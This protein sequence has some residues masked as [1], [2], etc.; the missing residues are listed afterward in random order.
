M[1]PKVAFAREVYAILFRSCERPAR[2]KCCVCSLV[3][4][5]ASF[6]AQLF[7]PVAASRRLSQRPSTCMRVI[8]HVRATTRS[9]THTKSR[10]L[11]ELGLGLKLNGSYRLILSLQASRSHFGGRIQPVD[12][13]SSS[14]SSSSRWALL[15]CAGKCTGAQ[16]LARLRTATTTAE[17][18]MDDY[19]KLSRRS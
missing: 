7:L 18:T 6:L 15:V 12:A 5:L 17:T 9:Q 1:R 14:W 8:A 4:L 10:K 2:Q 11:I 19:D 16:T 3:R 13:T